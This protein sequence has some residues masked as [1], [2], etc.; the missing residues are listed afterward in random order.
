[1]NNNSNTQVVE[2]LNNK[3][4]TIQVPIEQLFNDLKSQSI[5]INNLKHENNILN[6]KCNLLIQAMEKCG[7]KVNISNKDEIKNEVSDEIKSANLNMNDLNVVMEQTKC[8]STVAEKAL[9]KHN[10]DVVDAI[11]NISES[12]SEF[13][14][15]CCET[16]ENCCDKKDCCDETEKCCDENAE[17][18]EQSQSA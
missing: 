3:G 8:T 11:L 5:T 12:P 17:C 9:Q 13:E 1:M 10:G 18:C 2:L 15:A 7:L 14:E 16:G 4:E 6:E